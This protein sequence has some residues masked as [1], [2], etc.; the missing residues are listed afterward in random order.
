MPLGQAVRLCLYHIILNSD[1]NG[2]YYFEGKI[3]S[4]KDDCLYVNDDFYT[5]FEEVRTAVEPILNFLDSQNLLK[6]VDKFKGDMV[7]SMLKERKLVL[8]NGWTLRNR[9]SGFDLVYGTLTNGSVSMFACF[10]CADWVCILKDKDSMDIY[11]SLVN[12]SVVEYQSVE[13][14]W[15]AYLKRFGI[16]EESRATAERKR[17]TA[18]YGTLNFYDKLKSDFDL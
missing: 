9:K 4:V 1:N 6:L 16:T 14:V 12:T 5:E 11:P 13:E 8:P 3:Y 17:L 10:D 15:Q 18:M 2:N 7:S